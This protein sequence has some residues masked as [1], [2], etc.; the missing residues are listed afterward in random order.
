MDW[1]QFDM[2]RVY[3]LYEQHF[4][5]LRADVIQ[6]NRSLGSV[7][8]RRTWMELLTR[9]EFETLIT[10]RIDEPEITQRWV[11]CIVRGHEH[12]FPGLRVA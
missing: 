6:A 12:E 11:R 1:S 9:A 3:E 7:Q 10:A 8:P 2:E 4:E 5:Q